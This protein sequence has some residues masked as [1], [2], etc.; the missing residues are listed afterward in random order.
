MKALKLLTGLFLT[1]TLFSSCI[2]AVDDYND[3]SNEISL[4]QLV[5]S[6]D[7]WYVDYNRTTGNGDVAFLSKAFTISFQNE[8][9]YANNNLVGFAPNGNGNGYG[10]QIGYYSTI[11][12]VLEIDHNQD[13][14]IDL[15]VT[16]LS[17]NEIRIKDT[18]TNTSY[19]LIGYYKS[20]FDYD[21]VFYNNIE[22]FL[23]EY[24]AWEK[25]YTSS[26]GELTE[27]DDE[28][29]LEFTPGGSTSVFRS[30]QDE[31]GTDI[32]FINWDYVGDYEVFDVQGYDDLK[33]LTLDYDSFG[34]EE[35]ELSV[36]NDE[37]IS[38]YHHSSGTTY[39]F[40]GLGNIQ[41]KKGSVDEKEPRNAKRFKTNRKTKKR[42]TK[43]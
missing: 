20:N 33:I 35:F 26:V 12:G 14:F 24:V 16:Q 13:G 28:N 7:L 39:E 5:A 8:R 40:T 29:F 19:Y 15:E 34:N 22:Y 3:Y 32:D 38:L 9:L 2:I 4:E 36:I 1:I 21:L 23:Q 6:Y 17:S 25:T 42:N 30:S 27:F 11:N 18:Y 43:V 37:K 41:Y 31:F 10:L